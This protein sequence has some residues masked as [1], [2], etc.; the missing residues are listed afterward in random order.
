MTDRKPRE[1]VVAEITLAHL[2]QV[3]QEMGRSLSA[4]ECG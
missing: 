3:A 2:I 4:K 1:R